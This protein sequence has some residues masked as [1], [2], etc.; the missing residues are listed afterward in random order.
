MLIII[1]FLSCS[2]LISTSKEEPKSYSLSKFQQIVFFF[3]SRICASYEHSF[4]LYEN[5][6]K[7]KNTN[8]TKSTIT[9]EFHLSFQIAI[10][11]KRHQQK[12]NN[13]TTTHSIHTG[14]ASVANADLAEPA[15]LR[16]GAPMFGACCTDGISASSAM[17]P[18]SINN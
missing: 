6:T 3:S 17:V 8:V 1:L 9:I 4:A 13:E 14:K 18:S 10:L 15:T 2:K 11:Q 5:K 12:N 7:I 16:H